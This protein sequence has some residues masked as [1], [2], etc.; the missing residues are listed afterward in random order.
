MTR[1]RTGLEGSRNYTLADP[2][3]LRPSVEVG[4]RHGRG[5]AETGAGMDVGAGLVVSDRSSGLAVDVRVRTLLVHPGPEGFSARA[6]A[7][8][9]SYNP[10][11]SA[12]LRLYGASRAV[13]G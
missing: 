7:V 4:P 11:P 13:V 12:P 8:S 5:D 3:W 9:L 1:L 10:T 2:L 6:V